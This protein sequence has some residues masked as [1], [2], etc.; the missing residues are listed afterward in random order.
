MVDEEIQTMGIIYEKKDSPKEN[1]ITKVNVERQAVSAFRTKY[2]EK[3]S[4]GKAPKL[5]DYSKDLMDKIKKRS[6]SHYLPRADV[7]KQNG[8]PK[9]HL[10]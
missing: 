8:D 4:N 10:K 6:E 2:G 9:N 3:M 5:Q 7:I 1:S